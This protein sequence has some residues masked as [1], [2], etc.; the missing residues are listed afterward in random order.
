MDETSPNL[1][2]NGNRL[3]EAMGHW[4]SFHDANVK[5]AVREGDNCRVLVHM[6]ETTKDVDSAGYLVLVKHHLVTIQMAGI[7]ECTLPVSYVSDC[8]FG[9]ETERVGE[10]VKVVFDSAID[11]TLTW[12]ALCREASLLDVVPCDAQGERLV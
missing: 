8:L 11:P 12:H 1:F 10:W 5:E 9:L 7:A 3:V 6:F 2:E 4:P